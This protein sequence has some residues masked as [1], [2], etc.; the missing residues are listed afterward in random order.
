MWFLTRI[1]IQLR[2][3]IGCNL[4]S[5]RVEVMVEDYCRVGYVAKIIVRR[6]V[7]STMEVGLIFIVLRRHK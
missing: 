7:H 4:E 2:R 1:S 6:I 5:S 3:G